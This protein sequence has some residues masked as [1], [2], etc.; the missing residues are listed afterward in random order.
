MLE[1]ESDREGRNTLSEYW[2]EEKGLCR[3]VLHISNI[4]ENNSDSEK[5]YRTCQPS[6][7]FPVNMEQIQA[8][9]QASMPPAKL[10]CSVAVD[11]FCNNN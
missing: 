2:I 7:G 8:Y 5:N 10:K 6:F 1:N 4:F 11:S 9:W 3:S